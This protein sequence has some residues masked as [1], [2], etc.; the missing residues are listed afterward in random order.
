MTPYSYDHVSASFSVLVGYLAYTVT[1]HYL[2]IYSSFVMTL[3]RMHT[4]DALYSLIT[5]F[6]PYF[7]IS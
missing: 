1:A 7:T 5:S 6:M 4:D 2:S 3:L